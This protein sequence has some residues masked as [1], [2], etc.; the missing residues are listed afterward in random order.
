MTVFK[1]ENAL[2]STA[3]LAAFHCTFRIFC[4][5]LRVELHDV[6]VM[7]TDE[8]DKATNSIERFDLQR[9]TINKGSDL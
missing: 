7:T 2:F 9:N 4:F 8:T 3:T 6:N 1:E 5:F